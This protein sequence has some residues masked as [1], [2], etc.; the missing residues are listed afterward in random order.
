MKDPTRLCAL[1]ALIL[2]LLG[3]TSCSTRHALKR[4]SGDGQAETIRTPFFMHEGYVIRFG[5]V[6]LGGATN[7]LYRFS[8]LPNVAPRVKVSFAINRHYKEDLTGSLA[9]SL[10]DSKGHFVYDVQDKLPAFIWSRAG[11]ARLSCI[12]SNHIPL[13]RIPARGTRLDLC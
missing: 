5:P 12:I 6:P 8:G 1:G 11:R 2:V 7:V 3:Q 10:T 9:I 13:R 4:Y